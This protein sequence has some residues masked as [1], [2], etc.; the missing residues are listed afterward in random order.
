[1]AYNVK[2][3]RLWFTSSLRFDQL[4]GW[5]LCLWSKYIFPTSIPTLCYVIV[6]ICD[7][8]MSFVSSI[9]ALC[10][11]FVFS[12]C[13]RL[14][15]IVYQL[16]LMPMFVSL[17]RSVIVSSTPALCGILVLP[18]WSRFLLAVYHAT[19]CNALVLPLWSR[20]LLAVYHATLCDALAFPLWSRFLLVVY[21][22]NICSTLAFPCDQGFC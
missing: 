15:L 16:S 10:G 22:A 20:F 11:T 18:L 13:S 6:C 19:L 3:S 17:I 5:P 4:H 2:T 12:L 9:P 8:G 1:M 21:H 14:L 7:Q